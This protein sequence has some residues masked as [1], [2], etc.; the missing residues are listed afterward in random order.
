MTDT[1]VRFVGGK[2]SGFS[3]EPRCS[4]EEIVEGVLEALATE[5]LNPS[6][7][8]FGG[9]SQY[10]PAYMHFFGNFENLSLAFG[11]D[12]RDP[13]LIERFTSAIRANVNTSAYRRAKIDYE[14][15]QAEK[16]ARLGR[17]SR[18]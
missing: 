9:P 3:G 13:V 18:V 14:R 10:D 11:I 8:D 4:V 15:R 5:T 12:T 16:A 1:I 7:A 17:V 2:F 6:L